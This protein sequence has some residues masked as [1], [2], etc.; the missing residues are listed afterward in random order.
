MVEPYGRPHPA[1]VA[2]HDSQATRSQAP[3]VAA[4]ATHIG[5]TIDHA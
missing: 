4:A 1:I 3:E 5:R 2:V